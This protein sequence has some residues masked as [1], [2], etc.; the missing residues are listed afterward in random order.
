VTAH[1]QSKLNQ[2][3]SEYRSAKDRQDS[4][5]LSILVDCYD[6]PHP[7]CCVRCGSEDDHISARFDHPFWV[8]APVATFRLS[9]SG[10]QQRIDKVAA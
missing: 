8:A 3:K 2:L 9:P 10:F 6:V 5:S 7:E 1:Q 4:H